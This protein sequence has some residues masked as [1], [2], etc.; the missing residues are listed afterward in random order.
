[1]TFV[2]VGTGP[3]GVEMASAIAVMT[4][5]TLR[6]GFRRI[7]PQSAHIVLVDMR[8]RPL[9]TFPEKLSE[10]ARQR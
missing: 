6:K 4:Q 8:S 9:A 5:T 10:A 2:M 3:T 1:M 7:D